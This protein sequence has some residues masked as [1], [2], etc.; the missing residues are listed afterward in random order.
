[1]DEVCACGVWGRG[2]IDLPKNNII[3]REHFNFEKNNKRE[4]NNILNDINGI[5][6]TIMFHFLQSF[7]C[8]LYSS[9]LICITE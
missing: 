4:S 7:C 8:V 5:N 9:L 2:K 1:M 3:S 6:V